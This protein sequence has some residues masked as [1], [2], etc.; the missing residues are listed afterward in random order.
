M[1]LIDSIHFMIPYP[2]YIVN[3]SSFM[4]MYQFELSIQE[5]P[6]TDNLMII[7]VD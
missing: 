4:F 6:A 1:T 2:Q 3:S 7:I 5:L